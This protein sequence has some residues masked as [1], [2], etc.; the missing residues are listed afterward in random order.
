M[1]KW[2]LVYCWLI[3]A[4]VTGVDSGIFIVLATCN[5]S[6]FLAE[7]LD[8]LLAQ[9]ETRWS[10]LIRDD[11]SVDGTPDIIRNYARMDSRIRVVKDDQGASGSPLVSFSLLLSAAHEQGA[12]FVFCCDQDDHWHP[13]KLALIL[14]QFEK[15][16]RDPEVPCLI[17]HDLA[18]VDRNLKEINPSFVA[19]MGLSPADQANPQRLLSRNEVTGCS[20]A[21]NRALLEIALPLPGDAIMHDWWLALCAGYFGKLSFMPQQLVKYR[22]HGENVIGAKSFWQGLNPFNNWVAG[23]QAGNR[24]F[25]ASVVQARAFQTTMAE[26][27][28]LESGG[29]KALDTYCKLPRS[30]RLERLSAL[31]RCSLWR[32]QWILDTVLVLR[33]LLLPREQP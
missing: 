24:E 17:H 20:M 4:I 13:D 33:M 31:K 26:R 30:G 8:S 22:Q 18:V 21:C 5:G 11:H 25:L 9:S 12:E 19:M 6:A 27:L 10:L 2:L 23:W 32:H 3:Q 1:N 14:D 29:A 7:Q 15:T 28:N 16:G